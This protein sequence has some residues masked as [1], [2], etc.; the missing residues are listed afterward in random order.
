LATGLVCCR[1][2]ISAAKVGTSCRHPQSIQPAFAMAGSSVTILVRRH[3]GWL[4][5]SGPSELSTAL[6]N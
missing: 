5:W 3:H 1:A 4:I 2:S 6:K